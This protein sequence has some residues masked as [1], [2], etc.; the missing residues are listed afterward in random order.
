MSLYVACVYAHLW[1]YGCL[2]ICRYVCTR[3]Y[4]YIYT[5]THAAYQGTRLKIRTSVSIYA[6]ARQEHGNDLHGVPDVKV[7]VPSACFHLISFH[8]MS[9]CGF[10]ICLY[11]CKAAFHDCP[12]KCLSLSVFWTMILGLWWAQC[13]GLRVIPTIQCISI[14]EE[15]SCVEQLE[16]SL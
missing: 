16:A 5:C 13:C 10:I 14:T 11:F 4:I 8:F 2:V 3:T 6:R 15:L 1:M 12:I 7:I 9:M